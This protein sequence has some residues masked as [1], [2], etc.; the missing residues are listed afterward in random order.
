M[1][2]RE[3]HFHNSFD[4]VHLMLSSTVF[5]NH[6]HHCIRRLRIKLQQNQISLSIK[7]KKNKQSRNMQICIRN[8][9]D[10][11]YAAIFLIC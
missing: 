10:F 6:I 5:I 3:N 2:T 11:L 8:D 7:Q 1:Q 4:N 9:C